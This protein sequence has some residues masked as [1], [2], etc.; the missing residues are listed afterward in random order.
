M[1]APEI[2]IGSVA[3]LFARQM[4]FHNAGDVEVGHKHKFDHMTLLASGKLKITVDGKET[5]F[6]AP[7]MIYIKADRV[8]EL[9]ALE[10]DTIAYC[11]HALRKDGELIRPSMIPNGIKPTQ[12]AD[13]LTED[14]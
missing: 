11:V 9:Q 4:H 5:I 12:I 2:A 10:D 3:N 14:R 6:S 1:N 8:H 13:S 7:H